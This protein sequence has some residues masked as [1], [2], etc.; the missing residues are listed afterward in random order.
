MTATLDSCPQ[1]VSICK[2]CLCMLLNH[3]D[4]LYNMINWPYQGYHHLA[5]CRLKRVNH[6]KCSVSSIPHTQMGK[7][8]LG[9]ILASTL[10]INWHMNRQW[11]NIMRRQFVCMYQYP[12]CPPIALRTITTE[13]PASRITWLVSAFAMSTLDVSAR[14]SFD[15]NHTRCHS[16]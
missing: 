3:S 5:I 6:G 4:I 10:T 9:G 15:T 1:D 16:T 11:K 12:K 13:L 8:V 7:V 2:K 14:L